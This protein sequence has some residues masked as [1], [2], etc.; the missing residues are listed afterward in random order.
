MGQKIF[1][2]KNATQYNALHAVVQ[3]LKEDFFKK[4]GQ[5]YITTELVNGLHKIGY[6]IVKVEKK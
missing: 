5:T 6:E 3:N 4:S 1:G 2:G